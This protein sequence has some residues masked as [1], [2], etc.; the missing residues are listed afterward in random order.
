MPN[1]K[2][3]QGLIFGLSDHTRRCWLLHHRRS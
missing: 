2:L 1:F 3:L